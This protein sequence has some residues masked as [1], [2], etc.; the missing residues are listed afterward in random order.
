MKKLVPLFALI[1]C[2]FFSA[3]NDDNG[4]IGLDLLGEELGNQFTDST[5]IVA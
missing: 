5:E 2:I 1:L 4:S 3:C